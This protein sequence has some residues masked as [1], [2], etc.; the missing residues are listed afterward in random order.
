M[1]HCPCPSSSRVTKRNDSHARDSD[2]LSHA[3]VKVSLELELEPLVMRS[4]SKC[5]TIE[6]FSLL[7]EFST[8]LRQTGRMYEYRASF[9]NMILTNLRDFIHT[10]HQLLCYSEEHRAETAP[11]SQTACKSVSHTYKLSAVALQFDIEQESK[12]VSRILLKSE[13]YILPRVWLI[14]YQRL[15]SFPTLLLLL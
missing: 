7:A 6:L 10:F 2:G 11:S 14:C 13:A 4:T 9:I 1:E 8:H 5:F 12:Q 3:R 15:S